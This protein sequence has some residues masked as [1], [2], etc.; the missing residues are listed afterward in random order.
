MNVTNNETEQIRDSSRWKII[1]PVYLDKER[2]TSSGRVA[3]FLN[4]VENPTVAEIAEICIQLGIP[5]KIERKRHPKDHKS[6]GR[7]RY[8]LLDSNGNPHNGE[9]LN[10]RQFLGLIG[11]GINELRARQQ[12]PP[13]QI[14]SS[15]NSKMGNNDQNN[16]SNS[17]IAGGR[18]KQRKK[19]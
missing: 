14:E 6:L 15:S 19:R 2:S 10:K 16:T 11:S 13:Q 3:S 7:V 9:I 18:C 8:S 5:C 12:K 1:Y 4:S 17:G